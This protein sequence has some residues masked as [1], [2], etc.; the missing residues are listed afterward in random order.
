MFIGLARAV[1][2]HRPLVFGAA[3]AIL[4]AAAGAIAL[5]GHLTTG[6]IQG[7]ESS[8]AEVLAAGAP[9]ASTSTALAVLFHSDEWKTDDLRFEAGV[10][11]ALQKAT[12]MAEVSSVLSPWDSPTLGTRWIAASGH[13]AMAMVRLKGDKRDAAHAYSSV[14]A[15]LRSDSLQTTVT[16]EPAFV[17]TLDD[18]MKR[19]LFLA[20]LISFPLALIVLLRVFRTWVAALLPAV[21]GGLAVLTGTAAVLGLSHFTDMAQYTLNMVSLIGMGVAI[22]YSLFIV[23]RFRTELT[24]GGDVGDALARTL[25]TAGRAVAFSGLAVAVG[26]AGLLFFKGSYLSAL[27]IGGAVVVAFAVLFA[28]TVLPAV[29]SVLG[30]RIDAGRVPF[31]GRADEEKAGQGLWH[32]L[33]TWVMRR[34]VAVLLPTLVVLV[35]MGLPFRQLQ[36]AATDVTALPPG[37]EPRVGAEKLQQLFPRE[38]ATRILVAVEF[39][40]EPFTADRI[41]AMA[42]WSEE[43]ARLPGVVGVEGLSTLDARLSRDRLV[44]LASSPEAMRPPELKPALEAFISGRVAVMQVLT[45]Q[46]ASS[47]EARE[48]V[49]RLRERRV[50]GD[51]QTL[52]GGQTAANVDASHFIREHIPEAV[53]FVV[54]ITCLVL[55][56]LLG[57][58][59]L[60]LKAMAMNVLSIAGS[61]GALVWIF[62]EGH[63]HRLLRFEPGPIEPSLPILLFCL[64]FGLS[65]DYEVL[66]LS[67]IREEYLKSGDNEHAVAEGLERTGGLITNAAAIMVAVFSAFALAQAIAVKAMGVGLAI[68]VALD[69]TLVRVLLVPATMRLF[70]HWNWWAP[71]FVQRWQ[72]KLHGP[73]SP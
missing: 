21:V 60:P 27:G 58:V 40:G 47:A 25:D 64:L 51:A 65:M 42:D 22:D 1:H 54:S 55:F 36:L 68:A 17:A 41:G 44:Q 46:K 3:L 4:L 66:L 50:V 16:G 12:G 33:A 63:L 15:S 53:A 59:L 73:A 9:A 8:R 28:L 52:I 48:L 6:T 10:R 29:L 62:Q 23:S 56:V 11:A 69:A 5:G 2:R 7:T 49:H 72:T 18:I 57:S 61:F 26:L 67:R 14:R 70:G 45:G 20:E 71:G 35:V 32:T 19:D 43:V 24:R 39:P 13:D 38:A 30:P 37:A 34:P 31:F